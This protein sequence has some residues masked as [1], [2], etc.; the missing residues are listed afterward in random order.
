MK[1]VIS[2][3]NSVIWVTLSNK[4]SYQI[5]SVEELDKIVEKNP[6]ENWG[7]IIKDIH[8]TR[9]NKRP[10]LYWNK[11]NIAAIFFTG[12]MVGSMGYFLSSIVKNPPSHDA[13]LSTQMLTGSITP[14][15]SCNASPS[16]PPAFDKSRVNDSLASLEKMK[17][18]TAGFRKSLID[19]ESISEIESQLDSEK[20]PFGYN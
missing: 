20:Y 4:C 3:V 11:A 12:V 16:N 18:S 7:K 8:H 17:K 13:T 5:T 10:S 2:N 14:T 15:Q 9:H 1:H 6:N 19:L